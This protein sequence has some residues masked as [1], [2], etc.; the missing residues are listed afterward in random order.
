ME[1][2]GDEIQQNPLV[3]DF[4]LFGLNHVKKYN[5]DI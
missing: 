4:S 2:S 3:Y 5:R 1:R